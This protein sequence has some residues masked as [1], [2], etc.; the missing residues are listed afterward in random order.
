M[1]KD[2]AQSCQEE[3]DLNSQNLRSSCIIARII[4]APKIVSIRWNAHPVVIQ[5]YGK[6]PAGL[7]HLTAKNGGAAS[8]QARAEGIEK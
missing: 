3:S 2:C 5:S 8:N 6:D 1:Y 4:S 7:T